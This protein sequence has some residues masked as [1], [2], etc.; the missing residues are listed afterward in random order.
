VGKPSKRQLTAVTSEGLPE[1]AKADF[2]VA[3]HDTE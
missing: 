2:L 1:R 3:V